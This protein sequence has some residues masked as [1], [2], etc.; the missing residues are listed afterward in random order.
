MAKRPTYEELEKRLKEFEKEVVERKQLEKRMEFLGGLREELLISANLNDKLKRITDGIV[1]IFNA[2]FSR[3]WLIKPGDLCDSGCIHAKVAEG[4]HVCQYREHCLH[5][6]VSSGRYTHIDGEVHRRVPFGCYKIGRVA[7]EEEPKFI[8]NNV[9]HDSR[10]HDH[11]WAKDLRLVSFAGY[12]LL[13]ATGNPIGVLALFSKQAI[14][15][16]ED[17]LLEDL[18]NTT[19]QI[20]QT[21][22]SEEALRESEGKYRILFESSKDPIYITTREGDIIE[23]NQAH[24]DLFGYT[25]EEVSDWK[26]MDTYVD[27][28]DRSRFKKEIEEYGSVKGF[29]VKLRNKDG[30]EMDC[31]ITATVRRSREGS[32]LGYQGIIRNI[33]ERKDAE[34]ALRE[35]EEKYRTLIK[36]AGEAIIVAQ[37]GIFKFAN[38]KGEE[39]YG[40]SQE[41]LAS[42][43]L[44]DF[45]HEE[46]R[47]MV[48]ERHKRRLRGE[49]PPKTYP[50]RIIDKA[51]DTKW[52]QLSA[53]P[54]S[55]D[56]KPAV[57]CYI[58]GSG[59][60]LEK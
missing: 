54:L 22:Q 15:N 41:E 57:L 29:E 56:D 43:P 28:D 3:I 19:A 8:T 27:P 53:V 34:M 33:T 17:A 59:L 6:Q 7:S 42:R 38:P 40:R 24:L 39:L 51:G 4:P 12:R 10:V 13:S 58:P 36:N 9:T 47:D 44:T 30:T 35:S 50:F 23:A 26:A 14:S 2:D 21:S 5:L 20:V 52:V 55:W 37:D 46:D 31:L 45:I 48:G 49:E 32:I 11:E 1:E 18:A 16:E 25:R 60:K